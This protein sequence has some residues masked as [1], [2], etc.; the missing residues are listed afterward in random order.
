MSKNV[1]QTALV[2]TAHPD[3]EVL[4]CGGTIA[5]LAAE[6]WHVHVIIM[7]EG[8]T[9]RGTTRNRAAKGKALRALEKAAR[10]ANRLL[11]TASLTLRD[12]PD[13]RMDGVELLDIVKAVEECVWKYK[14]SRVFTHHAHDV[15]ID[16]QMIHD[17]VVTACRPT[18]DSPVRELLFFEVASSTEW[19]P[20]ASRQPFAPMLSIDISG[21]LATKV[22]AL[23]AYASEIRPFPHPRSIKAAEALAVWRGA[24]CG[25][26]AAEAF[27]VGYI[28]R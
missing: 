12:F 6:G 13:N 19:R 15:N 8:I 20:A 11:G 22:E 9:S 23:R 21:H 26:A 28:R 3:D 1:S 10:T 27:E 24:S 17:A 2:F 5:R 18:P 14:P 16:H 7:A 4:G 25:C